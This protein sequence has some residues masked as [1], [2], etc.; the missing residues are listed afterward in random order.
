MVVR[1]G[2]DCDRA[3]RKRALVQGRDRAFESRWRYRGKSETP[4]MLQCGAMAHGATCD[5]TLTATLTA[6]RVHECGRAW[7]L[8]EG[9]PSDR[10]VHG[11]LRTAMDAWERPSEPLVGGS[12]PSGRTT[13]RI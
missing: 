1:V 3:G 11:R 5:Q 12:N 6:T 2:T 9:E 10:R 13:F 8:A 7:T 4:L